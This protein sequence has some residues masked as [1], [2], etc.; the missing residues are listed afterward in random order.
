MSSYYCIVNLPGV[1]VR[2]IAALGAG[3]DARARAELAGLAE[4]WPGFETIELYYGERPVFVLANPSP[5]FA[6][7]PRELRDEAA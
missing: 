5:G 2:E 7:G 1:P 6:P 3:D 4:R